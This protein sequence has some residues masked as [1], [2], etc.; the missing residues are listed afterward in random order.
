MIPFATL[1]RAIETNLLNKNFHGTVPINTNYCKNNLGPYLAGLIE[2]DGHIYVPSTY[3]NLKGKKNV[4]SIEICFDIKDLPLFEKIKEVLEGG[5]IAIR[6]NKKSGRLFLR[7]KVI[8]LKVI[9]LINGHMRTPKIEALHR[10]IQWFNN[11]KGHYQIKFLGLDTSLLEHNSWLAG[12]IEADG[13]F[14]LNWKIS[15]KSL[16]KDIIS[17]IYYFRLSQRQEYSRKIDSSIKESNIMIMSKISE[18]LKTSVISINRKRINYEENA[19]LIKTDKI[20]SKNIIFAYLNKYPLFGYKYFAHVNLN[21]IHNLI[22]KSEHK[23]NIGKLRFLGYANSMKYN[24][25]IH[26]WEHLNKFYI[27]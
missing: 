27:H 26:N 8:L 15:D 19:F 5:Y 24:S 14:Y 20:E 3:R 22:I 4:P 18:F 21:L 9:N 16:N 1:R 12:F 2:G 6:P 10:L 7:K 11:E 13:N 23:T 17:V 25:E